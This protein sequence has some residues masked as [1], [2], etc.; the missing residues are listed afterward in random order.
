[1]I[2]GQTRAREELLLF[3][4]VIVNAC[5]Q[6][7]AQVPSH[8]HKSV[9]TKPEPIYTRGKLKPS[10]WSITLLSHGWPFE[11]KDLL[12]NVCSKRYIMSLTKQRFLFLRAKA[13]VCMV[14]GKWSN[15]PPLSN[16]CSNGQCTYVVNK[17]RVAPS[18]GRRCSWGLIAHLLSSS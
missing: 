5:W 11:S 7:S 15:C 18:S 6:H 10:E 1:M 3:E 9:V 2:D 8:L 4:A 12:S 17:S 13:L 14:P 16:A